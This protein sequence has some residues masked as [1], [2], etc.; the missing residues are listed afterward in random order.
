MAVFDPMCNWK[1]AK[2]QRIS[3]EKV[4]QMKCLL[5]GLRTQ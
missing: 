2:N 4:S 3:L 5:R 1:D